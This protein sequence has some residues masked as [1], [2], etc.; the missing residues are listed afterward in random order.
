M[1]IMTACGGGF[2]ST[3]EWALATSSRTSSARRALV[4]GPMATGISTRRSQLESVQLVTGLEIRLPFGMISSEPLVSKMTLAR[5]PMRS[6]RPMVLASICTVSPTL[7]GRSKSRIRPEM[8]L[9]MRFCRPNPRP[10]PN[11]PASTA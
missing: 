7:I 5:M 11:A 2:F 8:K 3:A 6:T 9:F 4:F 1:A 10:T